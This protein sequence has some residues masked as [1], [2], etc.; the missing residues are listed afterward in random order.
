LPGQFQG[1]IL[2][3][4]EVQGICRILN[5]YNHHMVLFFGWTPLQSWFSPVLGLNTT[6]HY[7]LANAG[8]SKP[9]L[10][11]HL[12]FFMQFFFDSPLT[13]ERQRIERPLG[14]FNL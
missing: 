4:I 14:Y 11:H 9:P 2:F 3:A 5:L 1:V 13:A 7:S 10:P 8:W 12:S 6:T